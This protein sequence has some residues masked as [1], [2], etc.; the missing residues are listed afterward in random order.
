MVAGEIKNLS[1]SSRDA[2]KDSNDTSA[3][4]KKFMEDLRQQAENLSGLVFQVDQRVDT[5][6]AATEQIA[7]ST[8][9][10][11][12]LSGQIQEELLKIQKL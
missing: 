10:V 3:K 11:E 4:V 7:A 8:K 9:L 1:D 5:L 6:A 2:A 12:E